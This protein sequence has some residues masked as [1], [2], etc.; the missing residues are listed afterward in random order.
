MHAA[1]SDAVEYLPAPHAV[2][3][4]APSLLPVSVIDPAAHVMHESTS[5]AV[6]YSPAAHAIHE[7][8]P[9]VVPVSVIEP[10]T[11]TLQ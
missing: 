2:H 1:T 11:H 5:D 3:V 10:A 8:A 7:R 4:V 9:A 6:E